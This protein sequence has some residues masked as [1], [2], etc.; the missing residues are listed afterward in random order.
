MAQSINKTVIIII[1]SN[2]CGTTSLYN[3]LKE[4]P[5]IIGSRVKMTGF[6]LD[7]DYPKADYQVAAYHADGKDYFATNFQHTSGLYYLEASPDYM[8]SKGTLQRLIT[9]KEKEQINL[10]LIA[11][12]RDPKDRFFSM[13]HHVKKL[14]LVDEA[15]SL[16]EFYKTQS[17]NY[18]D[19][20][21]T[22]VLEMGHYSK[23]LK[24]Y[25]E[26]LSE[27][28]LTIVPFKKLVS[29]PEDVL[30][31]L[32]KWIGLPPDVYGKDFSF[33]NYNE[34]L[35]QKRTTSQKLYI[36]LRKSF[37][38]FLIRKPAI[39]NLLRPVAKLVSNRLFSQVGKESESQ[40]FKESKVAQ[41][42]S[43]EYKNEASE[44]IKLFPN[45]KL[46]WE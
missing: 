45:L 28:E 33:D 20:L 3:Y 13:F 6:F 29:D 35:K 37:F 16:E 42:L 36:R 39:F 2:R 38:L 24:Q 41:S 23:S 12:L 8:Y 44:L 7:K 25:S 1:G 19:R 26:R 21:A 32:C 17:Q 34:G 10:K 15:I 14:D 46:E 18:S 30:T 4:H 11:L 27:E 5:Q 40:S 22:S 43:E 9:F 31:N